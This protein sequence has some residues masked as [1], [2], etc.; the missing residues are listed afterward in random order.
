VVNDEFRV[1]L[2]EVAA[3]NC[4]GE[5]L[6]VNEKHYT[7]HEKQSELRKNNHAAREQRGFAVAF[8]ARR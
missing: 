4:E 7:Q 2:I 5:M 1:N 8:V 6:R 3:G